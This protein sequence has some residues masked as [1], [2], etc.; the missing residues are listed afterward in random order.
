MEFWYASFIIVTD[1]VAAN[2][3]RGEYRKDIS[4][5]GAHLIDWLYTDLMTKA[6]H[7]ST[8]R[9]VLNGTYKFIWKRLKMT[10][11]GDVKADTVWL[12]DKISSDVTCLMV[13]F[14]ELDPDS[15]NSRGA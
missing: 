8:Y 4:H 12:V 1:W 7:P 11:R 15:G 3:H 2:E 9:V 6:G 5:V 14:P 10:I 13:R